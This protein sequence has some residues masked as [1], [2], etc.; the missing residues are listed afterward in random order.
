MDLQWNKNGQNRTKN[1]QNRT[2]IGPKWTKMN[3][4]WPKQNQN[5]SK[6]GQ[7]LDQTEPKMAKT[8]LK[9]KQN[10]TK[11]NQ[12]WPKQNQNEPKVSKTELKL[13]QNWAKIGPKWIKNGQNRTK[14]ETKLGKNWDT[15]R[16]K[17]YW[18]TI[19]L[20]HKS[21]I[22]GPKWLKTDKS[23]KWSCHEHNKDFFLQT[24][25]QWFEEWAAFQLE[26]LSFRDSHH[27]SDTQK[28]WMTNSNSSS[29]SYR[30]PFNSKIIAALQNIWIK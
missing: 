2:K 8:E 20:I 4:N 15:I 27:N 29:P 18:I 6:I 9:L 1:G 5:W 24:S 25:E 17:K 14:I 28:R 11:M 30:E 13:N 10:W 22:N 7:K 23:N 21:T 12:K 19:G 26:L 16:T 3:E